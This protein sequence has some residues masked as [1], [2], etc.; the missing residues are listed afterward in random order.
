MVEIGIS[1]ITR[2]MTGS[3]GRS[4]TSLM[5]ILHQVAGDTSLWRLAVAQVR[6]ARSTSHAQMSPCQRKCAPIVIESALRPSN[7]IMAGSAVRA[8]TAFM[9]VILHVTGDAIPRCPAHGASL[10]AR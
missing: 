10:M 7:G 1:P 5:H 4:V 2:V 3:A 6:V 9:Y 8:Q